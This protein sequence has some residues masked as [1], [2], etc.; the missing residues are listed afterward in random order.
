MLDATSDVEVLSSPP[1]E[2]AETTSTQLTA[3]GVTKAADLVFPD[4]FN[5]W[6]LCKKQAWI[7]LETNPN[8]FFYRHV[9]PDERKRN[10]SWTTEETELFIRTLKE[11]PPETGHWGL[12]ARHISGRVGYQCNAYY[13]K[14]VAA[15][16]IAGRPILGQ[17][18]TPSTT[19]GREPS[20]DHEEAEAKPPKIPRPRSVRRP[21]SQFDDAEYADRYQLLDRPAFHFVATDGIER[22]TFAERLR[23]F[24]RDPDKKTAF[25]RKLDRFW[26]A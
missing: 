10:G 23:E 20:P 25:D 7:Q 18:P 13:K 6:T 14:L 26:F 24:M 2:P 17:P 22:T 4:G 8:A 3:S 15:G 9:L 19:G 1:Q 11:H 21:Q 12:F 5:E 16:A